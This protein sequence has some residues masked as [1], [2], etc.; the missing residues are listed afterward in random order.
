[1][2]GVHPVEMI[3]HAQLEIMLDYH[4]LARESVF[5]EAL[6]VSAEAHLRSVLVPSAADGSR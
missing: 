1:M 5:Q 4:A 3:E 2:V 6:G